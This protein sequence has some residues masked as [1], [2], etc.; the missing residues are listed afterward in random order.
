MCPLWLKRAWVWCSAIGW[1]TI[2][3]LVVLLLLSMLVVAMFA[4][5]AFLGMPIGFTGW[6]LLFLYAA[7]A[8]GL[9]AGSAMVV[10]RWIRSGREKRAA[11]LEVVSDLP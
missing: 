9:V 10:M 11:S 7:T 5:L 8:V 4:W 6:A 3:K 2:G 1:A